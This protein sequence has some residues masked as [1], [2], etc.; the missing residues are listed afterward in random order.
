MGGLDNDKMFDPLITFTGDITLMR[1]YVFCLTA[2][3]TND[4]KFSATN[5]IAGISR[6][7]IENPVPCVS[8]R[9]QTY[10]NT[11]NV[12]DMLDEAEKKYGKWQIKIHT[13]RYTG[14]IPSTD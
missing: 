4:E 5:F 6:F 7:G 3:K 1:A 10:G 13:K 8:P 2:G 14:A 9:I 12:L 11:R